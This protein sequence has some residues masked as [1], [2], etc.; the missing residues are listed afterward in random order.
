VVAVVHR[1]V[2]EAEE[3]AGQYSGA[4]EMFDALEEQYGEGDV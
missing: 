1:R 4:E 3:I 2:C